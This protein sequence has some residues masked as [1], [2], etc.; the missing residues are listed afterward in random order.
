MSMNAMI[1]KGDYEAKQKV[2][3]KEN[4]RKKNILILITKYLQNLGYYETSDKLVDETNLDI[5]K[6]ETADNID[7][8]MIVREYEEYFY[9]KFGKTPKFVNKISEGKLAGGALPKINQRENNKNALAHKKSSH[10]I[11]KN[12]T[13]RQQTPLN[14]N[15][16]I[17]PSSNNS[18]STTTNTNDKGN[19]ELKLEINP[20][21]L[22][23]FKNKGKNTNNL[24]SNNIQEQDN[25]YTFNDHKESILLKPLPSDMPDELKELALLIKREIILENP[26]VSF[27]DIAGLEV[28]KSIIDEALL[29]PMKYPQF[30]TG[31]LEPWKG[32]LL[33]GPPG[34]GKTLLAKAVASEMHSTFFN[35]SAATVVSKWRGDSEKLI[36]VLFDLARH[37]QPSTIFLDEIDSIM[38][39]RGGSQDEHEGSRRMKT[40]LLIQL[41][42]L[43]KNE[44]VFL[45]AASN[46]PWDLDPAL[47]RRLEKRVIVPLPDKKAR[48]IIMRGF[49]PENRVKGINYETCSD[50]LDG[51]SGSDIKL[52]CKEVLMTKTR[53]AI[54]IIEND[55]TKKYFSLDNFPILKEDFDEAVKKVRPAYAYKMEQYERW[56]KEF[57][58][59]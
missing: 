13:N 26:N 17:G 44:G 46:N 48:E 39:S 24:I 3:K 14:I 4:E 56:M 21:N 51:Y 33:F 11:K 35:I 19:N 47:L 7:L 37:Y 5:D 53:K 28:P 31:I 6:Y 8:Y 40:E 58:S 25:K 34:T 27:K 29:W 1:N 9:M 16:K 38:S 36:K 50:M 23:N 12:D 54:D 32:I 22:L 18:N 2:E 45:L 42:G 49:I 59:S 10:V 43:T 57:G 55:T 20:M 41:D 15:S 30:F 52:V